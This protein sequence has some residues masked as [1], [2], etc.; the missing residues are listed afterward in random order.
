RVPGLPF[1]AFISLLAKFPTCRDSRVFWG[2]GLRDLLRDVTFAAIQV[3]H[4]CAAE[5]ADPE[6]IKEVVRTALGCQ[7]GFLSRPLV[8]SGS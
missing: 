6:L 8:S 4:C 2:V 5:D 1:Y 3:L 7:G